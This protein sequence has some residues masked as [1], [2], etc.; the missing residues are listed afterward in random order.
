M[1]TALPSLLN[2]VILSQSEINYLH[3]NGYAHQ[4]KTVG[5]LAIYRRLSPEEQLKMLLSDPANVPRYFRRFSKL[6][7]RLE[8]QDLVC[9]VF[10]PFLTVRLPLQ[11][12]LIQ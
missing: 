5:D 7:T 1:E 2:H 4:V 9:L 12:F 10:L 11:L 6:I 8:E 3:D